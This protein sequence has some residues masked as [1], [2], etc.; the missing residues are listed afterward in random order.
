MADVGR[1][2]EAV[3]QVQRGC[4]FNIGAARAVAVGDEVAGAVAVF[5]RH[6]TIAQGAVDF[7]GVGVDKAGY[8]GGRVAGVLVGDQ[9][10]VE[11]EVFDQFT[12][13]ATVQ[14]DFKRAVC[15]ADVILD[16]GDVGTPCAQ[17]EAALVGKVHACLQRRLERGLRNG[18]EAVVADDADVVGQGEIG[19]RCL[20][21]GHGGAACQQGGEDEDGGLIEL[22][23]DLRVS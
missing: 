1:Q 14:V 4:H 16:P 12:L 15:C 23:A 8:V 3:A 13:V 22:H 17:V 10:D 19:F 5:G 9:A 21:L 7:G 2:C 6:H 11:S 18:T 20:G